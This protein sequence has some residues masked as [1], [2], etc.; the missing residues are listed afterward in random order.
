MT[1]QGYCHPNGALQIIRAG[2]W[3]AGGRGGWAVD[4]WDRQVCLAECL[5]GDPACCI[6]GTAVGARQ[7]ARRLERS[8]LMQP[9]FHSRSECRQALVGLLGDLGHLHTDR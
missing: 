2:E 4:R 5:L 1:T 9:W 6:A 8:A 7:R 3:T